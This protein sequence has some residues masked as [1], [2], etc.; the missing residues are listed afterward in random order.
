[1]TIKDIYESGH[2]FSRSELLDIAKAQIAAI[3]RGVRWDEN[4]ANN[5]IDNIFL[6]YAIADD[7]PS[8]TKYEFYNACGAN[9]RKRDYTSF[10]EE[11]RRCKR[12]D[13]I[14]VIADHFHE[15]SKEVRLAVCALAS[16]ICVCDGRVNAYERA[17]LG[18]IMML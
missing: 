3:K 9:H 18:R 7:D 10:V 12:I 14:S 5:Y 11:T 4:G 1:M 6:T 16:V 15:E 17:Y 8:F 13:F 2:T